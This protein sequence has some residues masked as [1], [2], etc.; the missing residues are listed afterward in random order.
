MGW[1]VA[2]FGETLSGG[3]CGADLHSAVFHSTVTPL[4]I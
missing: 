4:S 1:F 3:A 2:P